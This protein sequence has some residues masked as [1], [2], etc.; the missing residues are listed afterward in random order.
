MFEIS[1]YFL[2]FLAGNTTKTLSLR[3]RSLQYFLQGKGFPQFIS[4]YFITELLKLKNT[5]YR[6]TSRLN[7]PPISTNV[8]LSKTI[9]TLN[10]VNILLKIRFPVVVTSYFFNAFNTITVKNITIYLV[11]YYGSKLIFFWFNSQNSIVPI[12]TK[13]TLLLRKEYGIGY[14]RYFYKN[15]GRFVYFLHH[16]W[17]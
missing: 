4:S 2:T 12:I 5:I 1:I 17:Y 11:T 10:I 13:P 14:Q 7:L 6:H 16:Y 3:K 8:S 15:Y 9:I